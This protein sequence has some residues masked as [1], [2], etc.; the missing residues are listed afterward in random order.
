MVEY[1]PMALDPVFHALGDG[2][3]RAMLRSLALAPMTITELAKPH[4]MSLAAASKHIKVL[5]SAGLLSRQV[6]G[7]THTCRLNAAPL[8]CVKEWVDF[9]EK[10]WT[11]RL[12]ALQ[13]L[14]TSDVEDPKD[15]PPKSKSGVKK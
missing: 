13:A 10:F 4:A 6:Q 7:R 2:T 1:I 3:R 15:P 14:L 12:D 11:N 8:E 9:Y 5:E